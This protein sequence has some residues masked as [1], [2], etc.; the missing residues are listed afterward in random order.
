M[1]ENEKRNTLV[2]G[3]PDEHADAM[4]K[5]NQRSYQGMINREWMFF[6]LVLLFAI[7]YGIY[8]Y[9]YPW[10]YPAP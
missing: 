3:T 7:G 2:Q 8:N 10:L 6:V 1:A 5:A 4:A 9:V